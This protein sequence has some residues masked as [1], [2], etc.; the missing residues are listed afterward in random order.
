VAIAEGEQHRLSAGDYVR[1][2][3]LE[4]LTALNGRSFEVIDVRSI[5]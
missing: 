4:G 5:R 3:E 2:E 1:F